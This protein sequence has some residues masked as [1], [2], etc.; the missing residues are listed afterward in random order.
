MDGE[1]LTLL[2]AD[3]GASGCSMC[4]GDV[5]G[6]NEVNANDL[7]LFADEYGSGIEV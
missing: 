2:V 3:F 1:D 7:A 6:D 5:N 4:P